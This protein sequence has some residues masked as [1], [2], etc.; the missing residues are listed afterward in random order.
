M[1][2]AVC[3]R[4][5]KSLLL[6]AVAATTLLAVLGTPVVAAAGWYLLAPPVRDVGLQVWD[7]LYLP[8]NHQPLSMWSQWGRYDDEALC[9]K[10]RGESVEGER[11]KA[12]TSLGANEERL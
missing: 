9:E 3:V 11:K 7:P 4:K 2:V 5:L 10:A 1:I 12:E 8:D 6:H